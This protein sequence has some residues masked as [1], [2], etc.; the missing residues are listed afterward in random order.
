[1]LVTFVVFVVLI[2]V[3]EGPLFKGVRKRGPCLRTEGVLLVSE[4][5]RIETSL[6][7]SS[8]HVHADKDDLLAPV[9]DVLI[10]IKVSQDPWPSCPR[11]PPSTLLP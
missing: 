8:I 11:R 4:E 7:G 5:T 6:N 10:G 3:D 1:V 2:L 9:L